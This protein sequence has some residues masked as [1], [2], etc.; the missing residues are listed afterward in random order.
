MALSVRLNSQD[1]ELFKN[2]AKM[3][4]ISV[5]ELIRS[6]VYSKIE[7]DYDIEAYREALAEYNKDPVSYSHSEVCKMLGIE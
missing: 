5:S 3:N 7:D 6:A 4:N 2:Y 1:E